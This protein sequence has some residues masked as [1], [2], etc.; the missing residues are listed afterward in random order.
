MTHVSH[1]A[2]AAFVGIDWAD[3]KHDGCL[4]P[5]ASAQRE[6]FQLV[7]TPEAIDAWVTTLRTRFHVKR[8][9]SLHPCITVV[10]H[11]CTVRTCRSLGR[12]EAG[13]PGC[14]TPCVDACQRSPTPPGP[15]PP[16]Q[17]GVDRV[18][19]RVC[20]ARRHPG[21]ARWRGSLLCLRV[22]LST[23]RRRRDRRLRMTRGQCGW[24]NLHCQGLAPCT[25][26]PACP[27]ANP[28]AAA[29]PR[30]A[31]GAQRTLE[32]VGCS[33]LFGDAFTLHALSLVC[34]RW[35]TGMISFRLRAFSL[36]PSHPSSSSSALASCRSAVSKPSVNQP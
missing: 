3:A 21:G 24:L 34:R 5:A 31:A 13:P 7:H 11:G 29:Q 14:R 25:T 35:D 32:G 30:L 19:F 22:P 26:V 9:D 6:C 27:G 18:A 15:S 23:L 16:C 1:E 17:N 8:S 33:R 20:G 12:P 36:S 2:F 10:P 4:Q 28:N